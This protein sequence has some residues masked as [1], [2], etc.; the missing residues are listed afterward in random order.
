[1]DNPTLLEELSN[2]VF[3]EIFDHLN[4][5]DLFL[6]FNSLNTRIS[7]ILKYYRLHVIINSTYYRHQIE[8]LCH[9]LTFRSHQVISLDICDE[10]SDQRNIIEYLFERYK[11]PTLR[12]CTFRCL[13]ASS[14]L[15]NVIN[16]LKKQTQLVSFNIFQSY[17]A[18]NDQLIRNHAHLFSEMVLLDTPFSLRRATL[19]IHYDYP[20]LMTSRIITTNLIYLELWF[21]GS[22]D[23]ISIY[24]LIPIFRIHKSLRQLNVLIRSSKMSQYNI[25]F[26]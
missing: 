18:K 2:D 15:I 11:F 24:S 22:F 6:A 8:H 9:Y 3:C 1:M 14:K 12:F 25:N 5:L 16:Q 7:S 19:R 26:K 10:I 20:E 13:E 23:K 21:Y 17:D 4:V